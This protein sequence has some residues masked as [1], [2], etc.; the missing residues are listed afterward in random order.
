MLIKI[1]AAWLLLNILF[2]LIMRK[3]S[4]RRQRYGYVDVGK[5]MRE[6]GEEIGE[7]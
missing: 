5:I 1:I 6:R 3:R 2:V 4:K 7:K